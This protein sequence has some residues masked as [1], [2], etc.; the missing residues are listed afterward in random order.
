MGISFRLQTGSCVLASG[1]GVVVVESAELLGVG[2]LFS[3]P[4]GKGFNMMLAV[5]FQQICI[6][7]ENPRACLEARNQNRDNAN[8]GQM[9]TH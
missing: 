8:M 3:E 9:N 1:H 7:D 4:G 6:A 5:G 2:G